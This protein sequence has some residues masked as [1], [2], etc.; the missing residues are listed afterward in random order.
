MNPI[1]SKIFTSGASKLVDSI[2]TVLDNSITNT[3]E[4]MEIKA[5]LQDQILNFTQE[6][7]AQSA[8]VIN[9]EAKGNWLQRSWRPIVMLSFAFIIVYRY[10]LSQVFV[11]P[12]LELPSEF[13]ELLKV[14][15]GGYVIGRSFEKVASTVT[16]K[17]DVIPTKRKRNGK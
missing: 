14:G 5:K 1:I 8:S 9:T 2:G 11:L 12:N 15:L 3:E 17:I 4:K 7:I 16:D 10:F 6:T 13:W